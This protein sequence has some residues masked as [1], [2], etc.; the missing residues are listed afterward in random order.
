MQNIEYQN[1]PDHIGG[2]ELLAAS[3]SAFPVRGVL[4][5]IAP[6]AQEME[7]A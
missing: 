3:R 1:H 7:I 4:P 2:R 5:I 6:S